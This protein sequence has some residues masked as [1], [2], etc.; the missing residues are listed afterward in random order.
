MLKFL[1]LL[2]GSGAL[3]GALWLS[4]QESRWRKQQLRQRFAAYLQTSDGRRRPILCEETVVGRSRRAADLVLSI[5]GARTKAQKAALGDIAPC[6]L[7]VL[8]REGVTNVCCVVTRYF[9]GILL[10]AGGL[11][12]AYA[13][14]AKIALDA[15]GVARMDRYA[16]LLIACPYTFFDLVQTILPRFDAAV[17]ECEYG[18]DVTM[19]VSLPDGGEGAL[20]QALRD[21]TAGQVEGVR[22]ESKMMARA[23]K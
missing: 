15:A 9:G 19:T 22:I 13:H 23:L 12:R 18:V 10:G 1:W 3:L 4:V 11:T 7:E 21:A 2:L 8:R 6:H 16:V 20:N 5:P 14:G 17:E